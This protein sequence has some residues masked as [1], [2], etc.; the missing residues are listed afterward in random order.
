MFKVPE[1]TDDHREM[2]DEE[3]IPM[4]PDVNCEWEL[5]GFDRDKHLWLIGDAPIMWIMCDCR[6]DESVTGLTTLEP[7]NLLAGMHPT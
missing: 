6:L 3:L 4:F 7:A 2:R 5:V 1:L